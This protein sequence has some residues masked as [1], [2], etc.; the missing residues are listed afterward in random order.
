M[1]RRKD[2]IDKNQN[3][4]VT[5]LRCIP[6]VTVEVGHDD[7][8]VGF[9]GR[10]YWFEIKSEDKIGKSGKPYN[11]KESQRKLLKSWTGHYDIV[12]SF[13]EIWEIINGRLI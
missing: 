9:K 2:R 8:L 12:S 7:I 11:L 3:D 1:R 13:T 5:Q 4:I 6:G 10:N